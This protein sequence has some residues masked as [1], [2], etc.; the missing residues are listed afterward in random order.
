MPI[1]RTVVTLGVAFAF[2]GDSF[3]AISAYA[4]VAPVF[5]V[6]QALHTRAKRAVHEVNQDGT[7]RA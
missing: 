3:I 6:V 7:C 2:Y 4:S 5:G 1:A